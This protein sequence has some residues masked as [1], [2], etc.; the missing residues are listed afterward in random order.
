MA[1]YTVFIATPPLPDRADYVPALAELLDFASAQT[2]G[3]PTETSWSLR[4]INNVT[5]TVNGTGFTRNSTDQLPDGGTVTGFTL[6]APDGTTVVAKLEDISRNA[7]DF[8][9][10]F[11]GFGNPWDFLRWLMEGNDTMNGG[12]ADD[13]L[14]S[15]G[16]NDVLT[17]G[18]GDDY[19][20]GGAGRDEFHG[21]AGND[22]ISYEDASWTEGAR[23]GI[24][25]DVARG[26]VIDPWGNTESFDG[27]ETFRGSAF[28]D[29]IVGSD[30][31]ESFVG[32][33]GRDRFEGG[34]GT[35]TVNYRPE[36]DRG[37]GKGA[38]VDLSMGQAIDG[39]GFLDTL[40]SIENVAGSKLDDIITGS[41]GENTIRGNE[42]AD[43]VFGRGGADIVYGDSGN[44]A[45]KGEEGADRLYGGEGDDRLEG[46]ADS[47][48]L[49]GDD[50]NDTLLGG[51]GNDTLSGGTGNDN[52]DGGTED[53][54]LNGDDGNDMLQGGGGLDTLN[55]G[56]GNDRISGGAG[57][58]VAN[59]G[60]GNDILHGDGDND[61]LR[62]NENDDSLFGDDGMDFLS[63]DAGNDMLDG[64][65]AED[66]LQGGI[67]NDR[68][69]GGEG[70]D[71]LN[72]GDG[73][74][75]LSGGLGRDALTGGK[76]MDHFQFSVAPTGLN[77]DRIADFVVADDTIDLG[78]SIFTKLKGAKSFTKDYLAIGSK[79]ADANDHIIYNPK[80][81]TLWYDA[82]G[83]GRG[84]AVQIADIG[85]NLKLTAADF[86][87]IA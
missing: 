6:Y 22:T 86:N 42:G 51:M 87:L 41:D 45:L 52:L 84:A 43:R 19:L 75:T 71:R 1:K 3:T 70:A 29:K 76:G 58:D 83:N 20:S 21:G 25:L 64:G 34:N 73:N 7:A 14:L 77:L 8:A 9:S 80:D 61:T 78:R 66:D 26:T 12:D 63:G 48:T 16:G 44:D 82:D 39:F 47:D 38:V 85:K 24:D 5:L 17:G 67:G 23:Q 11:L 32:F 60:I 79:A 35:D 54:T 15:F 37:A 69:F 56:G 81:G 33:A 28:A 55:G 65:A 68:L 18:G 57:N 31:D 13:D 10:A 74:D 40:I 72:G 50:G 46:G 36:T 4:D 49:G 30:A 53:D 62:G 27:V 59:G 2:I